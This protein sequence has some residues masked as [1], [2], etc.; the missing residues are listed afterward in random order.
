MIK[1]KSGDLASDKKRLHRKKIILV[2]PECPVTYWSYTYALPFTGK[3]AVLPPL[4]LATVAAML[5]DTYEPVI[6]DMNVSVLTDDMI[7]SADYIFISAMIV[8]KDSFA[9]I[10]RR[11]KDL[12]ACVVAGGPYPTTSYEQIANVDHFVL[13]E[14]ERTLPRFLH[15]LENGIPAHVYTDDGDKPPMNIS[16]VPRFDLFARDSYVNMAL[17]YSRGCPFQCE[18]CDIVELFGRRMR[19]KSPEQVIKEIT[20]LYDLGWRDSIFFVD[21]NFIGHVADVKRLLAALAVWQREHSFPFLFYTEA[22]VNLASDEELLTLMA[23]AGFNMVFLGIETPSEESLASAGK[24]Q[25]LKHDLLE[26]IRTIQ[27]HGMEVSAG[28]IVGFDT[29]TDDI[30]DRQIRFIEAAGIP[31]AMVGLLTALPK[32]QL[33]RRLEREGRLRA[34]SS[35][36]NTHDLT[37]NFVP[38]LDEQ[39]V[40]DG[41]KKIIAHIYKP[42]NYFKRCITF[43]KNIRPHRKSSRAFKIRDLIVFARSLVRQSFSRYGYRYIGFLIRAFFTRISMFSEAVRLAITG[44]HFFRITRTFLAVNDI[45]STLEQFAASFEKMIAHEL[46]HIDI[47][48]VL[49]KAGRIKNRY[50]HAVQKKRSHLDKDFHYLMS[51]AISAF[52]RSLNAQYLSL[53]VSRKLGA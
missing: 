39:T 41:Y 49:K 34:D 37:M 36:N 7:R 22:S 9:A 48:L 50:I 44:H 51:D 33:Y 38:V 29:D 12:G 11:C 43:L 53:T 15:D 14:A 25:N 17:Q 30:F 3:K 40:T 6:V 23:E 24:V 45:K 28:F 47:S 19:T 2:Y 13:N 46:P 18:F 26:S 10:A 32:T 8:Q 42:A 5:G 16:P 1:D 35:G 4:G 27:R 21:D 20:T 52:E 31:T